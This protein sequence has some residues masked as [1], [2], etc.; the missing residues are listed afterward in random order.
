MPIYT[1]RF[2]WLITFNKLLQSCS[3]RERWCM[4]SISW[5]RFCARGLPPVPGMYT[6]AQHLA[7]ASHH[8]GKLQGP[9]V[10][11]TFRILKTR[12][13]S[14]CRRNEDNHTKQV[15]NRTAGQNGICSSRFCTSELGPV[16]DARRRCNSQSLLSR[17]STALV[18]CR[19]A[20]FW[21]VWWTICCIA[22][23]SLAYLEQFTEFNLGEHDPKSN[24]V[25]DLQWS[26]IK[27]SRVESN[28]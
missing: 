7:Y 6:N 10:G 13:P 21:T 11:P 14:T 23:P 12:S 27:R 19:E 17:R 20:L 5:L 9:I 18:L 2:C 16:Q 26:G 28:W 25:G 4:W 24:A 15:A 22:L 3:Q 8:Q 1:W